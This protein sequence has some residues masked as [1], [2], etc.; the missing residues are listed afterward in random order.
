M[1][2]TLS[3]QSG[4]AWCDGK[5]LCARVWFGTCS[6]MASTCSWQCVC[7]WLWLEHSVTGTCPTRASSTHLLALSLRNPKLERIS[8]HWMPLLNCALQPLSSVLLHFHTARL[9]CIAV[10]LVIDS[11]RVPEVGQETSPSS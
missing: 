9:P 3:S 11:W 6:A 4:C 7:H 5:S 1:T 8:W 2:C 10:A